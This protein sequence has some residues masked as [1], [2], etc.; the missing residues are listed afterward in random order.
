[1]PTN[2]FQQGS[3]ITG[4]PTIRH[5][6]IKTA[7]PEKLGKFYADVFDMDIILRSEDG[8]G[9]VFVSDGYLTTALLPLTLE[10]SG[11]A[12]LDH[13]GF[14]IDDTDSI[15]EK[16]VAAGLPAPAMRP[17]NRPYAEKR[18]MDPDANLFDLSEHGYSNAEYRA[19][20]EAKKKTKVE[21]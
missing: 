7:D 20:R 12:G 17:S 5:I 15:S 16:L 14:A 18:G 21:A 2:G 3:S 8:A 6:A 1:L 4:R 13:F 19:D 10:G 9:G 11:S